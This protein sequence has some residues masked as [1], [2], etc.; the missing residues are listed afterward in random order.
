MPQL[1]IVLCLLTLIVGVIATNWYIIFPAVIGVT[2]AV[3]AYDRDKKEKET[4]KQAEEYHRRMNEEHEVT[5]RQIMTNLVNCVSVSQSAVSDIPKAIQAAEIALTEAEYEFN[6]GAF[7][8]FW[9]A[10]EQ[11]ANQLAKSDASIKAVIQYSK[12]YR[13]QVAKLVSSPP[14]FRVGIDTLPD[15]THTAERMRAIVRKAQKN[16]HFSTIYEQR[17]TNKLLVG[18]FTSLAEA[19]S[20][21]SDRL[22][23]SIGALSD[24]LSDIAETNRANTEELIA[25]VQKLRETVELDSSAQREH[26][27][28]QREMLDNI[29]RRRKPRNVYPKTFD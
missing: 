1:I 11:A 8:P 4:Q 3:I 21:M 7:A 22:E 2:A 9:D 12:N 24:S 16:F 13:D 26:E 25:S 10:V 5:Q 20:Q 23:S 6:D 15:A 27:G 17:K 28:K 29:Q 18:G 19:L 14:P